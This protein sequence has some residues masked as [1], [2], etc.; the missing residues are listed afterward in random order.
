MIR[1]NSI[2]KKAQAHMVPTGVS[3][4]DEKRLGTRALEYSREEEKYFQRRKVQRHNITVLIAVW[5]LWLLATVASFVI[6]LP[7]IIPFLMCSS[8]LVP[9]IWSGESLAARKYKK[10]IEPYKMEFESKWEVH[11]LD[12]LKYSLFGDHRTLFSE[13]AHPEDYEKIAEIEAMGRE[14][15]EEYELVWR[16]KLRR[17]RELCQVEQGG[18]PFTPLEID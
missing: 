16:Q 3:Q 4:E 2:I 5:T 6:A 17:A 15:Q 1:D 8:L 13:Y 18:S 10:P 14:L 11:N 7:V 12:C 9:A